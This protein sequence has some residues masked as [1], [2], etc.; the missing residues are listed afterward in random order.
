MRA[1][2]SAV[3]PAWSRRS[4]STASSTWSFERVGSGSRPTRR[5]TSDSAE[6]NAA[7]ADSRS[8]SH[9]GDRRSSEDRRW[10]GSPAV[11]PG[12]STRTDTPAR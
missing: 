1:A 9:S 11:L 2:R 12:V 3:W 10:T 5:S 7:R 4:A 8:L 6:D